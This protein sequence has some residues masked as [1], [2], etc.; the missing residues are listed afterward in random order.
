RGL[1]FLLRDVERELEAELQR[2][3]RGARGA[4]RRHADQSRHLPELTL[5]RSGHR[6]AH[7]LR[8]RA[9][10]DR[11]HLDRREVD[12]GQRGQRQEMKA[13][14]AAEHDRGHEQG[15]GD[16]PQDERPRRAHHRFP[17][18]GPPGPL[19]PVLPPLPPPLGALPFPP[20][21]PPLKLPP[22]WPPL[23]PYWRRLLFE[24]L[25]V[26]GVLEHP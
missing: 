15:R 13:D 17:W 18:P 21:W 1:H 9:R 6:L 19:P 23:R 4:R 16:R 3:D 25:S 7:H 24:P 10:I 11:L 20:P 26:G 14:Q 2:H 12:L 22:P 8:A 5:E